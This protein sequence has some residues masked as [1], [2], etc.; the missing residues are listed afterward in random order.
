MSEFTYANNKKGPFNPDKGSTYNAHC[1]V[2]NTPTWYCEDPYMTL[3][4][5][6]TMRDNKGRIVGV[7]D[8]QGNVFCEE[9]Y[10][11]KENML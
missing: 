8:L 1:P 10:P 3:G 5:G 2:C 7:I 11:D 6:F 9:C 4:V